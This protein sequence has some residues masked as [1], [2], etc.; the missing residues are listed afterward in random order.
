MD[1]FLA[2][3]HPDDTARTMQIMQDHM[4]KR[5]PAKEV[6]NRLRVKSGEY[7]WFLDR[8]KVIEWDKNGAPLRMVGTITD[9]TERKRTEVLLR[10]SQE[11][12]RQALYASNTGLWDW[13][14]DTNEV[15]FSREWKRQLGYDEE[16][17]PDVFETW[18]SRLHS[19]DRA[20]AVAYVQGYL[21]HPEGEYRQE[22]RL[23]H[24]DG[25]YRWIEARASFVTEP[26]GRQIRL[27]GSHTDITERKQDEG[28]PD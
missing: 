14:T 25:S 17:L 28:L 16:D 2:I 26:D 21:A 15:S 19:E 22:F 10:F 9:I 27:V 20:R 11:K 7:R 24:K 5:T 23:R 12:L 1:F 6:E 3:L 18:E 4:E 13:S 8:G